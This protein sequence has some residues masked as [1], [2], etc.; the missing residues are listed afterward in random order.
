[1][2]GHFTEW[3]VLP[4]DPI[5]K[6]SDNLWRVAGYMRNGNLQRQMV[7]ARMKDGGIVVHNAI[8][9]GDAEMK[10]I[11]AWGKPSVLYVPNSFHRQ[12]ALIWKKRYPDM[13]VV[14]P[15]G[16]R[17]AVSKVVAVERTIE[18]APGDPTVQLKTLAGT[19]GAG[20]LEVRSG[21]RLTAV[22]C[23]TILNM[24][25]TRGLFGFFLSPT[26]QVSVPR[27]SRVM[28]VKNKKAFATQIGA[29][30]DEPGLSRLMFAHG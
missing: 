28:L 25:R 23:D 5:E 6:M 3:T 22:F 20:V 27:V 29:L 9:L 14:A 19:P 26:G 10:E 13:V 30:A 18:D 24:K 2:P 15:T 7:L 1:M 21:D 16:A 4:H 12:D 17:K 8:A 11:E